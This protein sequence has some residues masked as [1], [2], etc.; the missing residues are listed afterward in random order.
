MN[1][2]LPYIYFLVA[3]IWLLDGFRQFFQDK[4]LYHIFMSYKTENAY[5]FLAFKLTI[6]IIFILA[7]IRRVKMSQQ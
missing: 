5:W 3:A 7:G 6:G 1:K 4:E 2:T